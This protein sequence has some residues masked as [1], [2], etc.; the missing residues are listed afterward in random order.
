MCGIAGF[1][2][3]GNTTSEDILHKMTT[4]LKHRGPDAFGYHFQVNKDCTIA[5]GH[6]RLSIIDLSDLGIQPMQ[7]LDG[8]FRI[9]FNGEI[10][11]YKEIREELIARG[12]HFISDSDT[13]VILF[14]FREWGHAAVH[15]FIGMFAFVLVDQ[16][17]NKVY[18]YRDRPGVKPLYYYYKNGH[19]L[20]ASELKA[21]FPFPKFE[22][23]IDKKQVYSFLQY[24]FVPAP[25][26]IFCDTYKVEPGHYVELDLNTQKVKS[27]QY[28]SAYHYYNKPVQ[29]IS[30]KEALEG[31]D[32]R[33]TK[34]CEYRMV[35]DVPVGVFLSGGYDSSLITA[36]LQKDRTEKIKTFTIGFEENDYNE[37]SHAAE[38]AKHLGTDHHEYLCSQEEAK[39]IVP[40][41][42]YYYDEPFGDTSAIPSILVS[43]FAREKVTVALSAD[44]GD[45]IFGGYKKYSAALQYSGLAKKIPGVLRRPASVALSITPKF[46]LETF[47]QGADTSKENIEK[48]KRFILGRSSAPEIMDAA[49]KSTTNEA[50]APFL[51]F[52]IP[53]KQNY[54]RTDEMNEDIDSIRKML[55]V[56]FLSTLSGD[57]LTKVDRAS[58]ST[59]LE[60]RE[61][62]LDQHIIEWAATLPSEYKIRNGDSK[63]LLKKLAHTYIPTQMMKRPK[64]G[65]SVP[66]VDWFRLDM[67][68]F[69]EEYL[70]DEALDWH[71]FFDKKTIRYT[72]QEYYN[73]TNNRFTLL[74][75]LLSFQMWYDK[76]INNR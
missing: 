46:I 73:G 21:F 15:K 37:A 7:I 3:F 69:F 31:L 11:N 36:V 42:P 33:I 72:L 27:I 40:E 28:W 14:A 29:E 30:E 8:A 44:A 24:G 56:D 25:A 65:F 64:M 10:Y 4:T 50:L 60:A 49:N 55:A 34:A 58:M 6:R 76:W 52:P 75:Y 48:Y 45:E 41:L 70:S 1:I 18:L 9:I 59:S 32:Q 71:G 22:K 51:T 20:F 2:D 74:W 47:M 23:A 26:S 68:N 13:E 57:I 19:F 12:Y 35:S 5:L 38:V 39:K 67:K 54:F 17:A 66:V 61:P 16:A 53:K 63:Y 43:R 62:L